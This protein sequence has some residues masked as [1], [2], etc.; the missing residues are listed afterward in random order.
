[1]THHGPAKD[2]KKKLVDLRVK[3]D[4]GGAFEPRNESEVAMKRGEAF[5][6]FPYDKNCM[7]M[8]NE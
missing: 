5:L 2:T 8:E 4:C 3:N 1:M 6:R 7:A